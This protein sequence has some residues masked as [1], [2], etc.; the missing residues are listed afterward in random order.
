MWRP[1]ITL[2]R[3]NERAAGR[4]PGLF[5]FRVTAVEQGRLAD[6]LDLLVEV[7]DRWPKVPAMRALLARAYCELGRQDTTRIEVRESAAIA[8]IGGLVDQLRAARIA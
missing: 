6:I 1:E 7:V 8:R 3:L 5:G 4:L 2:E